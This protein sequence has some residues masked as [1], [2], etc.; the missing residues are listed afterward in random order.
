MFTKCVEL[1]VAYSSRVIM[2]K[3]F[4][5]S[6][7]LSNLPAKVNKPTT[8]AQDISFS[9]ATEITS[10]IR[11]QP[12]VTIFDINILKGSNNVIICVWLWYD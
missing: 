11:I 10:F 1:T 12:I 5:P 4:F 7:T 2:I 6:S 9:I 3:L 8:A